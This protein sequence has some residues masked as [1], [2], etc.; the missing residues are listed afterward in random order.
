MNKKALLAVL[1]AGLLLLAGRPGPI[2]AQATGAFAQ[3]LASAPAGAPEVVVPAV[4][5]AQA[6]RA[7]AA[8]VTTLAIAPGKDLS[9]KISDPGRVQLML[10]IVADVYAGNPFPYSHDGIVFDNREGRLPAK[11]AGYYHEYTVLPAD[12]SPMSVTVGGRTF[13]IS[14]PQGH[15]GAERLIIGGGEVLYYTPNHYQDFIQLQVLR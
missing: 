2:A 5:P 14:P 11:P 9:P 8:A 1:S 10:K 7:A 3:L 12:G 4:V 13:A 6:A 15:R